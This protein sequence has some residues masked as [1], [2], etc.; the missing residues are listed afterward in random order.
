LLCVLPSYAN[1]K[2]VSLILLSS[3]SRANLACPA[4]RVISRHVTFTSRYFALQL[5]HAHLD[6]AALARTLWHAVSRQTAL[7]RRDPAS[8]YKP[9]KHTQTD[10]T[11]QTQ[12]IQNKPTTK[13]LNSLF[14]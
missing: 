7:P 6:H 10:H 4:C 2:Y 12:H 11:L 13:G 14:V 5:V 9:D 1:V 3:L 8:R